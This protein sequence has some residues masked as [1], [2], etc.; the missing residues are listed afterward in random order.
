VSHL[1]DNVLLLQYIR[2]ALAQHARVGLAGG[3]APDRRM[4]LLPRPRPDVHL[5]VVEE[6]ALPV[7]RPVMGGHRLDDEIVRVPEA[8]HYADRVLV[9]CRELVRH[10][11]DEPHVEAS[12]RDDIDGRKLLGVEAAGKNLLLSFEGGLVLRSHLRMTGR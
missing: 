8:V 9:G 4:R 6:L 5:P 3:R 10:A 11:L 7:E 12:E 1:S 2:G